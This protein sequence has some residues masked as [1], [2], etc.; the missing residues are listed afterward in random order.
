[1]S[2]RMS[3]GER[4]GELHLE[5]LR[6]Q[7]YQKYLKAL[8]MISAAIAAITDP[9]TKIDAEKIMVAS[10]FDPI[11]VVISNDSDDKPTSSSDFVERVALVV[12]APTHT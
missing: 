2:R 8:P 11:G 1:M 9:A 5:K 10:I 4:R 12:T 7:S 6:L 3:A